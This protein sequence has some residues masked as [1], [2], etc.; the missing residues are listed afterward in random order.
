MRSA[1]LSRSPSGADAP[2]ANVPGPSVRGGY[3][4]EAWLEA[5]QPR[6][7]SPDRA[8]TTSHD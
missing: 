1:S 7:A 6:D 3:D 4:P 8:A 2:A 5:K